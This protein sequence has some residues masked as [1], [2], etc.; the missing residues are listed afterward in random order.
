[1]PPV[2]MR[3]RDIYSKLSDGPRLLTRVLTD[4][5][6]SGVIHRYGL[7]R[8]SCKTLRQMGIRYSFVLAGTGFRQLG[9]S[10][11]PGFAFTTGGSA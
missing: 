8:R 11:R 5:P 2:R 7:L 4:D 6:L 3:Q 10:Q 1:M 9:D